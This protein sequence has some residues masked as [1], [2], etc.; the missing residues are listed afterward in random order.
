M[1]FLYTEVKKKILSV[2][3]NIVSKFVL[4]TIYRG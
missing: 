1:F 4:G 3:D 2:F